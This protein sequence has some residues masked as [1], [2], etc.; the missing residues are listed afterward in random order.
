MSGGRKKGFLHTQGTRDKIQASH[1]VR[2]LHE[3]LN[4][5]IELSATQINAA[6]ILLNKVLP[7]LAVIQMEANVNHTET[8]TNI[9]LVPLVSDDRSDSTDSTDS[10]TH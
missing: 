8:V 5:D 7:D 4:G 6:K 3:H 10:I 1:I 9:Q 2:R